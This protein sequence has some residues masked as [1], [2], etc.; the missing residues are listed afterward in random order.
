MSN[1]TPRLPD[2]SGALAS[3]F[4][5]LIMENSFYGREDHGLTDR[6]LAELPGILKWAIE[7]WR[8]LQA[9][10]HFRLPASSLQAVEELEDMATPV[11]AFLREKCELEADAVT[12]KDALFGAFRLWC[13]Q[14]NEQAGSKRVFAKNL[15]AASGRRIRPTKP[16]AGHERI[17]CYS[18]IKLIENEGAVVHLKFGSS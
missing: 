11:G 5:P 13:E 2:A 18:G 14:N 16:R 15:I 3:R 8:R 12:S 10:G 7:G 9:R 17:Q 6:L 4:I 1:E